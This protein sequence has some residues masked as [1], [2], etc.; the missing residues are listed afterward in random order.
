[1]LLMIN[2]VV[3]CNSWL[4]IVA[5]TSNILL[6]IFDNF[7][8]NFVAVMSNYMVYN[9]QNTVFWL[10]EPSCRKL[11]RYIILLIQQN[12]QRVGSYYH[13]LPFRLLQSTFTD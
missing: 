3:V 13:H 10:F 1:M 2:G 8:D 9:K 6:K 7:L 4:Q 5:D 11:N 12:I